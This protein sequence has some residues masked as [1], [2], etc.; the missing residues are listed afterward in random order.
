MLSLG[1]RNPQ[2]VV[3]RHSALKI[4]ACSLPYVFLPHRS[5]SFVAV[6]EVA[7]GRPRALYI[8]DGRPQDETPPLGPE[9]RDAVLKQGQ[10]LFPLEDVDDHAE[11]DKV[12]VSLEL[13]ERA[14][15]GRVQCIRLEEMCIQPVVSKQFVAELDEWRGQLGSVEVF[16][17]C[18]VC[19]E[20]PKVLAQTAADVQVLGSVL[21]AVNHRLV[22]RL[23]V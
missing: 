22:R 15:V 16:R 6:H 10:L 8:T 2:A 3:Q 4:Q 23:L 12:D 14:V 7:R 13:R 17:W 19:H 21:E 5:K 11:V 9:E 1:H 18:A 20:F